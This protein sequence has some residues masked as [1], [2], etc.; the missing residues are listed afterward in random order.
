MVL[1]TGVMLKNERLRQLLGGS[2]GVMAAK[3]LDRLLYNSV[4]SEYRRTTNQLSP[5]DSRFT[6]TKHIRKPH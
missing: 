6:C 1:L 2:G 4:K 3:D 5:V